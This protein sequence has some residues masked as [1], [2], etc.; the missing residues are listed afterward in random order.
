MLWVSAPA[1]TPHPPTTSDQ[2]FADAWEAFF[3]A[4]RRMRSQGTRPTQGCEGLTFPQFQL[5]DPLCA[6]PG[7]VSSLAGLAGV[8]A[9]TAT[10]ML[11]GLEKQGLVERHASD[12]DRRCV[13]IALTEE[14]RRAVDAKRRDVRAMRR[15]V[16]AQLTE[17]E[18]AQATALLQRLADAMEDL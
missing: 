2:E 7:K 1:T 18:R 12:E 15:K 14:G 16:A 6:G 13:L 3:R 5:L 8:S 17:E 10:R 11:D 4:V 9:P